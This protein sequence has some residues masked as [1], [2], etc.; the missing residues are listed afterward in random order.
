MN[1]AEGTRPAFTYFPFGGGARH[2]AG[3]GLA[4][5]EG[6]VI[7]AILAQRADLQVLP[8]QTVVPRARLTLGPG[9]PLWV[10]LSPREPGPRA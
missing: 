8:G 5:L 6:P 10:R 7:V 3:E 2:G 9:A 1:G 4:Q